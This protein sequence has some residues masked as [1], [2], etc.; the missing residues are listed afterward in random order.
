MLVPYT[1][2]PPVRRRA[3]GPVLSNLPGRPLEV[4]FLALDVVGA[5]GAPVRAVARRAA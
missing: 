3:T 2:K 5:Y 1:I 4:M